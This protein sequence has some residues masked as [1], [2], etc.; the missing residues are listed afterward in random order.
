MADPPG[1]LPP[2]TLP[3]IYV[4]I[5]FCRRKCDY[6]AFVSLPC[7]R[8]PA[9]Y[10]RA[11]VLQARQ[12]ADLPWCRE[13]TF[14]SIFI[15]GGTPTLYS[16]RQLGEL[17]AELRRLF[18]FGG[19]P[20]ISCESNP[21][22]LDYQVLRGL[23]AA[24]INRLSV[25]VQSF[26][27]ELLRA[28]GRGHD[29]LTALAVIN[30]VRRAGFRDFNLDLI[31]GL[32]GQDQARFRADL[33]TA[34]EREPTHLALYQLTVEENTPL[35]ARLAAGEL[36]LPSEDEA[37]AMEEEARRILEQQ[38]YEHYEVA[39]FCQPGYQ[40]RH[41]LNYWHNGSYL[42][43]GAAAFSCLG[44]L[45]LGNVRAPGRYCRR[46]A[47][48][49]VPYSEGEALGRAA[50]FRETVVMGLRLRRGLD[51]AELER[52]F[53][54]TPEAYYGTMLTHLLAVG[55]LVR[56]EGRLALSDRAFPLANQVLA[57][58]V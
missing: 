54:L 26:Q 38:V 3:G 37:A 52:R 20:E 9:S 18:R 1:P 10:L 7:R 16:P 39:N 25:G 22:T 50:A 49:R 46:L 19:E 57:Q 34:L 48:G 55:L 4:H 11:L 17:I 13:Q 24:G 53:A 14:G 30:Q 12:L 29:R 8:P 27:D 33:E 43:L 21:N 5:P 31:Y 15:G 40:C 28:V 6:C 51:L 36:A 2:A 23:L 45:R 41:N 35:A 47:G 56:E 44:G 58:L 32:P 42:G